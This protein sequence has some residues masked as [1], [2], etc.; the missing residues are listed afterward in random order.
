MTRLVRKLPLNL[1]WMEFT[2]GLT[3]IALLTR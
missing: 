2:L 3:A 1:P